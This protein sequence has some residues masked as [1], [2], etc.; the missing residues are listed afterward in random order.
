MVP[1]VQIQ[2]TEDQKHLKKKIPTFDPYPGNFHRPQVWLQ[3]EKKKK[4]LD[5]SKKQNLNLP[6]T[7]NYLHSIDI[8]LSIINHLEMI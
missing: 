3:K 6:M 4:N 8:V 2:P 1:C 7:G 5:S